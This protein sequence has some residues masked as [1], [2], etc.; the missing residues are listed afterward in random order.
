[1]STADAR[2]V[3][4]EIDTGLAP[5]DINS[6]LSQVERDVSRMDD[7]PAKGTD[8]RKDLEAVLAALRIATGVGPDSSD[9]T[10]SEVQHD[11]GYDVLHPEDGVR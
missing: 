11:G 9:R 10:A 4:V 1:M 6:I 8:D 3:Q 2:D 5:G 7:P